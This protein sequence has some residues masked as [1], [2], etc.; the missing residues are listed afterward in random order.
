MIIPI[1]QMG[2]LRHKAKKGQSWE[3]RPGRPIPE[4]GLVPSEPHWP[5]VPRR[6]DLSEG[7]YITLLPWPGSSATKEETPALPKPMFF[8]G[9]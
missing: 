6:Q 9:K 8:A 3:S 7:P 4:L 1:F 2:K 5:S